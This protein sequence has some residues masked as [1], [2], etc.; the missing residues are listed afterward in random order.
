MLNR[1]RQRGQMRHLVRK[2]LRLSL[3]KPQ[4]VRMCR[5]G[6]LIKFIMSVLTDIFQVAIT[7]DAIGRADSAFFLAM[8]LQ[9]WLS[10]IINLAIAQHYLVMLFVRAQYQLLNMDLR[11]VVDESKDLSYHPPRRGTYMTRCCFL[12]DQLDNIAKL[13][14]QLQAVLTKLATVFGIQGLMVNGGYYISSV[15]SSY[16]AY[17]FI[18]NGPE[19]LGVSQRAAVLVFGWAIFYYW[20]AFL[21]LFIILYVQDDHKEMTHMLEERTLFASGLDVR[22]EE[23]ASYPESNTNEI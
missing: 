14:S 21:N 17:S 12:A 18:K 23:S 9:F 15:T 1:W 22:L 8:F 11:R 3:A 7:L 6:I 13:Q 5:W 2:I 20:D 4:V 10:A 19:I 16:M